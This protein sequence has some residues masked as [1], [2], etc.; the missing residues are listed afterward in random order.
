MRLPS[1]ISLLAALAAPVPALASA[2]PE[3]EHEARAMVAQANTTTA[4]VVRKV[5]R[6]ARKITIAHEAIENLGMP[7]M[8]MVFQVKDTA[9]LDKVKPGDKIHFA[10]DKVNG[11][12]TV[13][14]IEPAK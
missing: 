1:V 5:D 8:T 4:G 6:D 11:A 12:Y 10:A 14:A 2:Q 7:K 9:M 3:S 13:T